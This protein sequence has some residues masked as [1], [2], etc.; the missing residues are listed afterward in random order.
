MPLRRAR[1]VKGGD[2]RT[3]AAGRE[4]APAVAPRPPPRAAGSERVSP[5]PPGGRAGP[6][7]AR[8]EPREGRIRDFFRGRPAC[9]SC[10]SEVSARGEAGAPPGRRRSLGPGAPKPLPVLPVT[11]PSPAAGGPR[12]ARR[13]RAA[14]GGGRAPRCSRRRHLL[15]VAAAAA[16]S[17][18]GPAGRRR[19]AAGG[20]R[21]HRRGRA[22]PGGGSQRPEPRGPAA[23]PQRCWAEF[24][25]REGEIYAL[26]YCRSPPP[27]KQD[28]LSALSLSL[29][30]SLSLSR[31][32]SLT[33]AR[34]L[35]AP[36][37]VSLCLV[38]LRDR[39]FVT[40]MQT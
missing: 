24:P 2:A 39:H 8:V 17:S 27:S 21:C 20:A 37:P 4:A 34:S 36:L 40:K 28:G 6:G 16:G 25:P 33:L 3:R 18:P 30:R 38:S 31:S 9:K 23:R 10:F 19:G 32:L 11:R 22:P 14:P 12:R 29:A 15:P 7:A 5:A 26:H 13:H 1:K 35:S